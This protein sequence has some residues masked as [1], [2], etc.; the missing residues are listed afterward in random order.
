[1]NHL[2][3]VFPV[4]QIVDFWA[5]ILF[6]KKGGVMTENGNMEISGTISK[7]VNNLG[8][9]NKKKKG[10]TDTSGFYKVGDGSEPGSWIER[11][12]S[13]EKMKDLAKGKQYFIKKS[14]VYQI[15]EDSGEGK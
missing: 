15:L 3:S 7:R 4:W 5:V 6:S 13:Q 10:R 1:M 8:D 11:N 9:S 14:D 12:P 2:T